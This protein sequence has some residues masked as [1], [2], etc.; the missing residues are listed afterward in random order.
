MIFDYIAGRIA[1]E[2]TKD[3]SLAVTFLFGSLFCLFSLAIS[4]AISHLDDYTDNKDEELIFDYYNR[5]EIRFER[6][7]W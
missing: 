3:Y 4:F 2:L 6:F 5:K 7:E 1:P